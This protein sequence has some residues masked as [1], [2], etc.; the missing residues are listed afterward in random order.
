MLSTRFDEHAVQI[1]IGNMIRYVCRWL[2]FLFIL[3][4]NKKIEVILRCYNYTRYLASLHVKIFICEW[5]I[6]NQI[7]KRPAWF[8]PNTM[9]QLLTLQLCFIQPEISLDYTWVCVIFTQY[10]LF[11][12][13]WVILSFES[14]HWVIPNSR[15]AQPCT[16]VCWYNAKTRCAYFNIVLIY[17]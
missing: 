1:F 13:Q 16:N 8:K 6:L 9:L 15:C 5:I 2:C 12:L 11:A 4:G 14:A 17:W 10:S 3:R 7:I